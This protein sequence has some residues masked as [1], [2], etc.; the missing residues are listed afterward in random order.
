MIEI[1]KPIKDMER[2]SSMRTN[3]DKIRSMSVGEMAKVL[4][5][6]QFGHCS[7]CAYN[8]VECSGNYFDDSSCVCGIKKWL[9]AEGEA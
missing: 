7:E 8:G 5:N 6:H 4:F 1:S 2:K 9:E 3:Y